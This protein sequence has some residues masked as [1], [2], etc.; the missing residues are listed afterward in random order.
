MTVALLM[1]MAT[2][3]CTDLMSEVSGSFNDTNFPKTKED[4]EALLIGSAYEPFRSAGYTGL[5]THEKVGIITISEM[6]SDIGVCNWNDAEW[7]NICNGNFTIADN[8]P[9]HCYLNFRPC[10]ARMEYAK[11]VFEENENVSDEVRRQSIA[12]IQCGLGW[13]GYIYLDLWGPLQMLSKEAIDNP[14]EKISTPRLSHEESVKFIEDNL[15]AAAKVLP[16]VYNYG[17]KNYG[18]FTK[19]LATT[20]LMKLYMHEGRWAEAEEC[21]RELMK[22][23]YGFKLEDNYKDIF[24]LE[25]E[26][27]KETI[28]AACNDITTTVFMW[29]A[30]VLPG[31]YQTT[32]PNIQKWNGFRMCWNFFDTYEEGDKRLETIISEYRGTDGI[33]Y[34]RR[35]PGNSLHKGAIPLKYGEDPNDTGNGCGIDVVVFRYADVLTLLSEAIVRN[36]GVVTQ[37]AVNLLNQVRERSL[38]G[39]GYKLAQV[40][41]VQTF[42]DKVLDERGHELY[43]EGHR[44]TD[45][46][47]HGKFVSRLREIKGSTTVKDYMQ[48]FPIPPYAITESEGKV[49]NNPGYE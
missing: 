27:N 44:R 28:W 24:T 23:Q 38:P 33:K 18:R 32:N 40:S 39:K 12:E 16:D 3:G 46:I 6:S 45:L 21:G 49:R 29:H 22:P 15:K 25:N 4:A 34:S 42:L 30:A 47:R 20:V 43:W 26:G 5:F 8:M 37:E 36:K 48:L 1:G 14:A 10:F 41:D 9:A 13:L 7:W 17:D 35:R 2:S 19:A 11:K 31:E